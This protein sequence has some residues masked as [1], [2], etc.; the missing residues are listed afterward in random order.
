VAFVSS[1]TPGIQTPATLYFRLFGVLVFFLSPYSH[2]LVAQM[3]D[4]YVAHRLPQFLI[5]STCENRLSSRLS[6]FNGS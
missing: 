6:A 4:G 1:G 2:I 5:S 3:Q